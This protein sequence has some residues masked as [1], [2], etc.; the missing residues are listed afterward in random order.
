MGVPDRPRAGLKGDAD[1]ESAR[2]AGKSIDE[3]LAVNPNAATLDAGS[4]GKPSGAQATSRGGRIHFYSV[5]SS[6]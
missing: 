3:I 2:R 5:I 1:A 6:Y 4:P